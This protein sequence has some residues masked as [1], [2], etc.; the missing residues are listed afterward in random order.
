MA[1]G[2]DRHG[3]PYTIKPVGEKVETETVVCW[4]WRIGAP[5]RNKGRNVLVAERGYLGDRFAWT[6]LGW[7]GLNRRA[8]FRAY[9]KPPQRFA[10]NFGSMLKPWSYRAGPIV[11]MGQVPG[12]SALFG[13]DYVAWAKDFAKSLPPGS[14]WRPHP[15]APSIGVGLPIAKG[16]LGDVLAYASGVVAYNSNSTLDAVL[17]GVPAVTIDE[18][19][20]AW[21]MTS[22]SITRFER[23]DRIEHLSR[24]AWCQWSEA[25]LEDGTAWEHVSNGYV[26]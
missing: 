24:I 6:S 1:N 2:L 5:L 23:P 18:G 7:N 9:N 22:R 21:E 20:M 3:V 4:G 12:D 11:F 8:D 10:E 19:A 25:E 13:L 26:S 15:S 16:S 17:A 14:L